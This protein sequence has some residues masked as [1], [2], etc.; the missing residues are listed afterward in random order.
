MKCCISLNGEGDMLNRCITCLETMSVQTWWQVAFLIGLAAL[1]V[2]AC[3]KILHERRIFP[4]NGI[5]QN[6][7]SELDGGECPHCDGH[8]IAGDW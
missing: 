3:R 2:F 1:G 4:A 5:C 8:R 7:L 6:C